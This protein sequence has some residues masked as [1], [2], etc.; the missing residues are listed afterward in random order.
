MFTLTIKFK[1]GELVKTEEDLIAKIKSIIINDYDFDEE[2]NLKEDSFLYGVETE[3]G[4]TY[5]KYRKETELT[6]LSIEEIKEIEEKEYLHNARILIEREKEKGNDTI[7]IILKNGKTMV[8][9]FEINYNID[10]II[11]QIKTYK[12]FK[13]YKV[14]D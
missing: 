5:R 10:E 12:H 9:V 11:E 6:K 3:V 1:P 4:T 8:S 13:I 7:I 14:N 2:G